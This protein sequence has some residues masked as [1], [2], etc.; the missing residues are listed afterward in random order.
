[1]KFL[2]A[3]LRSGAYFDVPAVI[4]ERGVLSG[5]LNHQNGIDGEL[6][7]F[8]IEDQDLLDEVLFHIKKWEI[9]ETE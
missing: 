8:I 7:P 5:Y 9:L 6:R 2:R 4:I 1:M 3:A